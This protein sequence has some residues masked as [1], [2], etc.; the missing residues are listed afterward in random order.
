MV[1]MVNVC[2]AVQASNILG[3]QPKPFSLDT[4]IFEPDEYEDAV[5]CLTNYKYNV[6]TTA[7][8]LILSARSTSASTCTHFSRRVCSV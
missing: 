1:V 4:H 5:R 2:I 3:V 7:T 6:K 8:R